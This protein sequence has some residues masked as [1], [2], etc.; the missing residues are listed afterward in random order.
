MISN[1]EF[2]KK[3]FSRSLKHFFHSRSGQF[4]NKIPILVHCNAFIALNPNL[5]VWDRVECFWQTI[6]NYKNIYAQNT[7]FLTNVFYFISL[8]RRVATSIYNLHTFGIAFCCLPTTR[9]FK[10]KNTHEM[11]HFKLKISISFSVPARSD[12]SKVI[13]YPITYLTGPKRFSASM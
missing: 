8:F 13:F 1:L 6:L 9:Y 7:T 4:W 3:K 5:S 2:Q 12:V 11:Q 10:L